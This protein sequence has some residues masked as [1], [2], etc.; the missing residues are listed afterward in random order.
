MREFARNV[1][2]SIELGT[3][4]F[5][6]ARTVLLIKAHFPEEY[7]VLSK[8]IED[9]D[10]HRFLFSPPDFIKVKPEL[11]FK[12]GS[13]RS[14]KEAALTL[15]DSPEFFP[16]VSTLLKTH[17]STQDTEH[18][19]AILSHSDRGVSVIFDTP[20]ENG[21]SVVVLLQNTAMKI[22]FSGYI[23]LPVEYWNF[24]LA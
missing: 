9:K 1:P 3:D 13:D 17:K 23:L 24:G 19:D 8:A 18:F 4:D 21:L 7:A 10:L 16:N 15:N 5:E 12:S 2:E 6:E 20:N 14:Q 22:S 11:F